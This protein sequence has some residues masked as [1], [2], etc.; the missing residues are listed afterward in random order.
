MK[1]K[2]K[3]IYSKKYKDINSIIEKRYHFLMIIIGLI[4]ALLL[5]NLFYIQIIKKSYYS[6]QLIKLT[7]NIVEGPTAPR[8]RIYDRNHRLIVDNQPIKV[9]YY[10]KQKNITTSEEI[11]LAYFLANNL[12]I[13][14]SKLT[15]SMI[16]TFWLKN[17]YDE[18]KKKISTSEYKL[19][20]ERK[21]TSS[22]I[23]KLKLERITDDEINKYSDID[24]EAAYIYY[25]MNKG[26]SYD[27]KI[28][29]GSD[30][31]DYE[32]AFI[33]S[34]S[35]EL[36]GVDVKLSWERSY[37]YG[38]VFKSI[39]GTISSADS[40]IPLE[41]KDYYLDKGYS[42]TDRVGTSYLEYQYD[43]YLRGTKSK[44]EITSNGK[45]LIEEGSR[46]NDIVLTI[47]IELQKAVEEILTEEVMKTKNEPNTDYYNR[48]FAIIADPKTGEILAMAGKQAVLKDGKYK[49]YDYTPGILTAPVVVGSIIKGASQIV[50]YNTGALQIGEVRYDNCVK[51]KGAPTKCSWM[52]LGRL[53]DIKALK[54]SSNTYQF[55]TAMKVAG[56][57][58]YYDMPFNPGS[59][60]FKIYRDTFAEFGLGVKTGIDLPLEST[61]YKG[62]SEVGGLLLD[63]SIGQYDNYTPIQLSQYIGTIANNG[64]RLK[65]YLLK[66]VYKGTSNLSE[67]I[68]EAKSEVLNKVNTKDEYLNRVKEG[69]KAVMEYGG[70]GSG[71]IDHS[72]NP[73]GKTGTSQSF[74]DSDSDGVIDKETIT[75]T[76][77]SYVPYDDPKVTFT[78]ISPDIYYSDTGST[79]QSSVNKRISKRISEKYFEI[80]G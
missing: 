77:A 70:T 73:A 79:Y 11:K 59:E 51:L 80:Y 25:L 65:P 1:R 56:V 61:G 52:S 9:I 18:A 63:F 71:Y 74:V 19:L 53:D 40:G 62:S 64:N 4:L 46:G 33:A 27:E 37:P 69:F 21:L 26:Y 57:S 58:Y 14:Y 50:G 24:R 29:K 12:E 49:I 47:D 17:N 48:S 68:Y 41:L 32:Y 10:K 76:F 67:K 44:Y 20:K 28:I 23:E 6:E 34:K 55:Y 45:T 15:E 43:E 2:I 30:V 60:P 72:H 42:L 13:N 5:I 7:R 75:N 54:Q 31:S 3:N 78:V 35:S 38:D 22:D 66:E 16:R 36:S 39:I 8:G